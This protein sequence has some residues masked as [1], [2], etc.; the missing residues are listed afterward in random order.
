MD[1]TALASFAL[2]SIAIELTPGP[3]MVWLALI[4]L[5]DGRRAGYAAVLGVSLGLALVGTAV[6]FGLGAVVATTP[7]LY[8]FL[9]MAG[10]LYLLWLAWEA[11]QSRAQADG[12]LT[13]PTG[14][15][16]KYF[17]RGLITNILNPKAFLFYMAVLPAFL[18]PVP[19][20]RDTA[21]LCFV[22]VAVASG[23][24]AAIVLGASRARLI[25]L[26]QD[27]MQMVGRSAA[28]ILVLLAVWLWFKT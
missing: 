19:Q 28:M 26:R 22:Y 4:T 3:N 16:A 2:A 17:R 6:A 15:L 27:R 24:H 23:I 21:A 11:W 8:Q 1:V 13:S 5:T 25:L 12:A 10:I 14:A 18:P 7:A 20:P 9:R